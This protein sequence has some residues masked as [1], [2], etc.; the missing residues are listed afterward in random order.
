[1]AAQALKW[2]AVAVRAR[3]TLTRGVLR[4]RR[5]RAWCGTTQ[6]RRG[7]E[8]RS[9]GEG[10]LDPSCLVLTQQQRSP[11]ACFAVLFRAAAIVVLAF[12]ARPRLD[13]LSR[14]S[15]SRT[16]DADEFAATLAL[17]QGRCRAWALRATR[18][19]LSS[20]LKDPS[21]SL[22]AGATTAA[23][24]GGGGALLRRLLQ[25]KTGGSL[26]LRHT[27]LKV[28][29][30]GI[31]DGVTRE[32][33]PHD[34]IK[35]LAFL[36][37]DGN[38]YPEGFLFPGECARMSFSPL[39]ATRWIVRPAGSG[40]NGNGG[41]SAAYG[42][43]TP[44]P[45]PPG[46]GRTTVKR[47]MRKTSLPPTLEIVRRSKKAC[48]YVHGAT[49]VAYDV[50]T[51]EMLVT[52]FLLVRQLLPW[53]VLYP[54]ESGLKRLAG[55]LASCV[56]M[57]LRPLRPELAAAGE[58]GSS[59]GS[60]GS[61]GSGSSTQE[62]AA[63][64]QAAVDLAA[65]LAAAAAADAQGDSSPASAPPAEPVHSGAPALARRAS[66]QAQAQVTV[67]LFKK[68]GGAAPPA[69]ALAESM[70][71]GRPLSNALLAAA[72]LP[73]AHFAPMATLMERWLL[74]VAGQL[75]AWI[76]DAL[77]QVAQGRVLRSS[78]SADS[79]RILISALTA[80]AAA[81]AARAPQVVY[82][83]MEEHMRNPLHAHPPPS[84]GDADI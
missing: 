54:W 13:A 25:A 44:R 21:L 46:G 63:A 38:Y 9:S 47:G 4:Q 51:V 40:D 20:C 19:P 32:P 72:L 75:N 3:P 48:T 74:P 52:N 57:L 17:Y 28:H 15:K 73:P 55:V 24:G 10:G 35:F 64:N 5:A 83:V 53:A 45:P 39:G 78:G 76:Q 2:A 82:A 7:G 68:S 31:I 80:A 60:S 43:T 22:R 65:R 23:D 18:L 34:I 70:R 29:V 50:S 33:P 14:K 59:S 36:I 81:A 26:E 1:M 16:Q 42:A 30:K 8:E 62:Q 69:K 37:A 61:G 71:E 77:Q 49:G 41:G 11:R 84:G 66:R 27:K 12:V 56:Y 58:S 6:M 67:A 79:S